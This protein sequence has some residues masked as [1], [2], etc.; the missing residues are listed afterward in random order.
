MSDGNG[1]AIP[2]P[3]T[4]HGNGGP[5]VALSPRVLRYALGQEAVKIDALHDVATA[6]LDQPRPTVELR[7]AVQSYLS[8][9]RHPLRDR[10]R[11]EGGSN[12]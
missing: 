1:R 9:A 5:P 3:Q 10:S 7:E 12:L 11:G 4:V 6:A 8:V 2:R